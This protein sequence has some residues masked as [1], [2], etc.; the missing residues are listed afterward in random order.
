MT[1]LGE[2]DAGRSNMLS[3]IPLSAKPRQESNKS[4][5]DMVNISYDILAGLKILFGLGEGGGGL[6]GLMGAESLAAE[7]KRVETIA[8]QLNCSRSMLPT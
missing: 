6:V 7:F 3:N 8:A 2:R 4:A 1:G 5:A